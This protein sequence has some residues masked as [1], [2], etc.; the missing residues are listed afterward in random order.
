M[1]EPT[2]APPGPPLPLGPQQLQA[3]LT[4]DQQALGGLWSRAQWAT[5][6]ADRERPGLGLWRGEHLVAMAC[7]WLVLDELQITLLAVAPSQ[8]RRGLGRQLLTAL[9]RE[10]WQRGARRSTLE[11]ASGNTAAISLYRALGFRDGGLR[12]GYYRDGSDALIQWLDLDNLSG[13]G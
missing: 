1:P 2:P 13:C 7:G 5:E 8:R 12:R 4:L 9:L 11:V 10:G 6:L 3:C